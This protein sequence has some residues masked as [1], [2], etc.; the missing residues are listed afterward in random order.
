MSPDFW[1]AEWK[2]SICTHGIVEDYDHSAYRKYVKTIKSARLAMAIVIPIIAVMV[3]GAAAA[4]N[5]DDSPGAAF[6]FTFVILTGI[7][8]LAILTPLYVAL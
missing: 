2:D 8:Y 3:A 4:A 5:A 1:Y 7:L 6:F